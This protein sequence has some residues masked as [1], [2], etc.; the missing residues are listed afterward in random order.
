MPGAFEYVPGAEL[1]DGRY[2]L[3]RVLGRGGMAVVWLAEDQ[4]LARPVAIKVISDALATDPNYL[5]RFAREARLAA[6]LTHPNLVG[7]YDYE[8]EGTPFLVME[9]VDGGTLA[10]RL[11]TGTRPTGDAAR[12]IARDLL[13]ALDAIHGAGVLHRDIKPANVLIGSDDRVH[14]TDF[15]IAQAEEATRL[16][17]TGQIVGTLRYL[18]P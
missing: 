13:S 14:L 4:R 12:T 11:T 16:T 9:F 18:A 5:K 7:I 6:G 8:T 10:D 1:A 2:K 15:G 17:Q 3:Q